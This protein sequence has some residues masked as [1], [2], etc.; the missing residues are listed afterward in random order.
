MEYDFNDVFHQA[1]R[2]NQ[3]ALEANE[4]RAAFADFAERFPMLFDMCCSGPLDQKMLKSM[5]DIQSKVA[6]GKIT[7]ESADEI[8]GVGL[9]KRYIVPVAS[10]LPIPKDAKDT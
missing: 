8:I 6:K 1:V 5:L 2:I 4:R 3:S 10:S 9:G 7:S